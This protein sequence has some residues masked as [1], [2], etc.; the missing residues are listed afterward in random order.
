MTARFVLATLIVTSAVSLLPYS[1]SAQTQNTKLVL[2]IQTLQN[3]NL[4]DLAPLVQNNNDQAA[5]VLQTQQPEQPD[6]NIA[7]LQTYLEQKNSP[8]APYAADILQ[9][10]NWKLVLAISN[11]ESTLCKHQM[12]NN[13]WG[14]GGA[15]N[16]KRYESFSEGFADVDQLLATKYIAAGADTPKKIVN[17]Y[18]GHPNANWVLAVNQILNQLNQLPLQN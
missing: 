17:R 14:V 9:N 8:L 15:W 1:A 11:G 3:V 10:D 7:I 12:Y 18:V 13:C 2:E 16:L 6:P 5:D 4:T